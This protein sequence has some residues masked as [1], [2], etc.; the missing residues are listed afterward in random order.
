VEGDAV[1]AK[2]V[3]SQI[4]VSSAIKHT[5][6]TK[7]ITFHSRVKAA[8]EFASNEAHG[9]TKFVSGFEVF[10]VHGK[11]K[12]NERKDTIGKFRKSS[13][14]IITNAKCLTEGVDVP[15]VDMVAFVDPR[16]SKIDIAQAVGRAMR[17]PRG[18]DKK[19]GYIVVPIYAEDTTDESL[20]KAIKSEGF[21]DVALILNSLMEQDQEL[22]DIVSELKQAKGRGEVFNPQRLKD[23]I[24]VIGLMVGLDE[25]TRSIYVE[26]VDRLGESWDEWYGLLISWRAE[27]GKFVPEVN[28]VFG[29]KKIGMWAGSQRTCFKKKILTPIRVAKLES[30]N[31]WT[32]DLVQDLWDKGYQYLEIY[33]KEHN[34][35]RVADLY[36][37]PDGFKLGSW[38]KTRRLDYKKG[39]LNEIRIAALE[40]FPDW[41]W[42]PNS[43]DW[44]K[45]YQK[46]RLLVEEKTIHEIELGR[47]DPKL[48]KYASWILAQKRNYLAWT[49]VIKDS[50]PSY[51]KL[52]LI[53][54]SLL[55]EI[56]GWTWDRRRE[57]WISNFSLLK[58][59]L[60]QFSFESIV[61]STN[62]KNFALGS[63][64][65]KQ[66]SAFKDQKLESW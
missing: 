15:A 32:W 16:H 56:P 14:S 49:S 25:L 7:I 48:K 51:P 58:D 55:E 38:V 41:S 24:E 19:I 33:F 44:L 57:V 31:G 27:T 26:S 3:A 34:S 61:P 40:V 21:D 64:L 11:Q 6:A 8:L 28:E 63:W 20:E 60:L 47:K 36:M 52:T 66:R 10:H 2:W 1:A 37:T 65:V 45:I 43:D 9:I 13:R 50:N 4:A 39:T 46:V 30:L 5:N 62:F 29:N 59:Y 23:K 53:E 54:I 35:T 22:I 17:K 18:G 12:S 42:N